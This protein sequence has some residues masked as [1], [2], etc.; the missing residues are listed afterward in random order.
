MELLKCLN[1]YGNIS[2]MAFYI[3]KCNCIPSTYSYTFD[4]KEIDMDKIDEAK[5]K[6]IFPNY[7]EYW[8]TI[9]QTETTT[10]A[11]DDLSKKY[12][13]EP[14]LS[15]DVYI[16]G[17]YQ[18]LGISIYEDKILWMIKSSNINCY[19]S[20]SIEEVK[21]RLNNIILKF[22]FK[23]NKAKEAEVQLIAFDGREY[24]TIVS[25]VKPTNANIE[26]N[27]NDDFL[28]VYEDIIKFLDQR[29]SGLIIL[30]GIMGSGKT[31]LIRHLLSQHPKEYIVV[32]NTIASH[33]AQPEFISFMLEH[34]DSIFI[35]EDCE[36]IL[37]DRSENTFGG[38]IANILNMSDGLMS[39]IFNIKFICTFNADINKIDSALLRKGRCYA[40][41]EFKALSKEKVNALNEKYNLNLSEIK[42]MTLADIY[43]N[44][45][46]DNY[47]SKNVSPKKKIGF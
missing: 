20:C 42:E 36:Q 24:Y 39:D 2:N 8:T 43:N 45:V 34:K 29:E 18:D 35:L 12:L 6:E 19:F 40:N 14:E 47:Q 22:P 13:D 28:P 23:T 44:V 27:Y 15:N 7:E 1:S 9:A 41:Y 25:K 17:H 33:L 11:V 38:A 10:S 5:L 30:R 16:D 3:S 31:T 37:M 26:E 4:K 32:T 46:S 21:D